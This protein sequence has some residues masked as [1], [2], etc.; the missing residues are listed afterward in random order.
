[1]KGEISEAY[2]VLKDDQLRARFDNGDDPNAQ[3]QAQH[4]FFRQG[5]FQ[6]GGNPFSGGGFHFH[7]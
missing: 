5:G 6:G 3:A 2:E 1:M 4:P 7:H